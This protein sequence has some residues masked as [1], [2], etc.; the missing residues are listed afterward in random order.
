MSR[1]SASS[2]S[3]EIHD[4]TSSDL[5][6]TPPALTASKRHART[7]DAP[8]TAPASRRFKALHA[9]TVNLPPCAAP[10]PDTARR[11]CEQ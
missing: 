4:R 5:T 10:L 3:D 1:A 2:T 8:A 11:F 9:P 7:S 6:P